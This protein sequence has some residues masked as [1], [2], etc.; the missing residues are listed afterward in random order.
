MSKAKKGASKKNATKTKPKLEY[1][2]HDEGP[3]EQFPKVDNQF[4]VKF[5]L[6][7]LV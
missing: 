4:R 6:A 2:L 5:E 7:N 1:H 3:G